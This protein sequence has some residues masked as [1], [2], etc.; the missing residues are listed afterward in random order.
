[1]INIKICPYEPVIRI[2]GFYTAFEAVREVGFFFDGES[3][4]SWECVFIV[5]GSAGVSSDE[6]VYTLQAGQMI[7]HP[8]CE[9]HRIWNNGDIDLKII[10]FSFQA[11]AF[12]LKQHGVYNFPSQ[13]RLY[14][15]LKRIQSVYDLHSVT[16]VDK[17]KAGVTLAE[18]Q[19][20]VN[21][22]ENYFIDLFCHGEEISPIRDKNAKTYS[23]ALKM[24]KDNLSSRVSVQEVAEA[25]GI[26]VSG[27]QKLFRRFAGIGV[28]KYYEGMVMER[29]RMML[30][31][32][33]RVKEVAF[34]LG[35][36]DQNYFSTVYKRYFGSSPTKHLKAK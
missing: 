26:S 32:G 23:R 28:A 21:K 15:V 36:E 10:I 14:Q 35:Y 11:A 2:T 30:E 20:A 16:R 9:F 25:C 29:A 17:P 24:M 18:V 7:I 5:K 31:D 34:E 22:L 3:H 33:G 6:A 27:L 4:N 12:P 8:P 1:M 13:E 19:Q